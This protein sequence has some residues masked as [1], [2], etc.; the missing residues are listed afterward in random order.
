[1]KADATS[2]KRE[3]FIE[4]VSIPFDLEIHKGQIERISKGLIPQEMEDKWFIYYEGPYLYL[5]R[6]WTGQ[7]VYRI[8]FEKSE[9]G[10]YVK[11]AFFSSDLVKSEKDDLEY[12]GKLAYF[13]VCNFLLG[14]NIPFP[15]PSG[16]NE[17]LPG[18]YQHHVSGTG[19]PEETTKPKKKW[20]QKWF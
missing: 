9:T 4:G 1:M 17:P 15:K 16:V 11:E 8:K 19:Y 12:Q 6:S 2:W 14:Q 10:Y 13:L 3:L 20:W 7:P 5:H 18:V